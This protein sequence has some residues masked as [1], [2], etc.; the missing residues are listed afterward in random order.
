MPGTDIAYDAVCLAIAGTELL[1]A[2]YTLAMRCSVL[3]QRMVLCDV[4]FWMTLPM[5][6]VASTT[7]DTKPQKFFPALCIADTEH[8]SPLSLPDISLTYVSSGHG[9]A[10]RHN[11]PWQYRTWRSGFVPYAMAVPDMA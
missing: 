2:A 1:V 6:S 11:T 8:E 4:H 3:R 10:G 9:Q 7:T 5:S